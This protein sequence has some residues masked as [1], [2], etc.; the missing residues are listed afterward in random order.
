METERIKKLIATEPYDFLRTNPHLGGNIILLGLSGSMAYGTNTETSDID[1]RGIALNKKEE[2]LLCRP[3]EQVISN[4]TDTTVYSF[5]KA[6]GLLASANPNVLEMLFLE[7][8]QYLMLTPVGQELIENRNMFLSKQALNTFGGYARAQLA[9]LKNKSV[10]NQDQAEKEAHILRAVQ[11]ASSSFQEKFFDYPND[12]IRLY[13]DETA[14]EDMDTEIFMD[15]RLTHY[16]LRDYKDMWADMRDIVNGYGKVGQRAK[17]AETR[18]T[19]NK[20]AMHVVRLLLMAAELLNTG[21]MH[22]Y[23]AKDREF[24]LQIRNGAYT[25]DRNTMSDEFFEMIGRLE[26]EMQNAA[27]KTSLPDKPDMAAIHSFVKRVNE[28]VIRKAI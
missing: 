13:V 8:K 24:L 23:R 22:T 14:K 11:N 9:R 26:Q 27:A 1:I 4:T 21:T 16:P 7:P 28:A 20:H 15:I 12:A 5:M 18:G 2:I 6:V 17:S 3:F 25:T 19:I 10:Q